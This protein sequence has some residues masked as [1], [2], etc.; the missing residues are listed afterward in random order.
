MQWALRGGGEFALCRSWNLGSRRPQ[1]LEDSSLGTTSPLCF[2]AAEG[3]PKDHKGV[4]IVL[5]WN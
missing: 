5:T 3:K 2:L 1:F 4:F